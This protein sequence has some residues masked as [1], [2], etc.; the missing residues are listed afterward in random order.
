MVK[1]VRISKND[2]NYLTNATHCMLLVSVFFASGLG[3]AM[4]LSSGEYVAVVALMTLGGFALSCLLQMFK[5]WRRESKKVFM[6]VYFEKCRGFA[7]DWLAT[8]YMS[9]YP[10]PMKLTA[11][12]PVILVLYTVVFG[13]VTLLMGGIF[14]YFSG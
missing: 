3:V 8:P 10:R 13:W 9:D 5:E 2:S 1:T 12:L 14:W 7:N 6:K 11:T 4:N